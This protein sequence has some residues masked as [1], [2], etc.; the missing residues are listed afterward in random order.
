MVLSLVMFAFELILLWKSN[1]IKYKS[2]DSLSHFVV[3]SNHLIS[4]LLQPEK[5]R[6]L[7][8]RCLYCHVHVHV[9]KVK[10]TFI[11]TTSNPRGRGLTLVSLMG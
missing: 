9:S 11:R 5:T 2:C 1:G 6:F 3:I 4:K 8:A 10:L 7:A